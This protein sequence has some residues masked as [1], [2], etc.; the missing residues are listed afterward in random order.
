MLASRSRFLL[1]RC[2]GARPPTSAFAR[3]A[4]NDPLTRREREVALLA[5]RGLSSPAMARRL[6]LSVRTVEN[7]L[8]RIYMKLGVQR[9]S[10]LGTLFGQAD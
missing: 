2:P 4:L 1:A 5:A 3:S 6:D 9:R 7:H 8:A 10:E